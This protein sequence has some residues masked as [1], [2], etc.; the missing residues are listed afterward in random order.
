MSFIRVNRVQKRATQLPPLP[1]PL[2]LPRTTIRPKKLLLVGLACSASVRLEEI[3]HFARKFPGMFCGT[4]GQGDVTNRTRVLLCVLC[5]LPAQR[6]RT[7]TQASRFLKR[8]ALLFSV[9]HCECSSTSPVM[10]RGRRKAHLTLLLLAAWLAPRASAAAAAPTAAPP[11]DGPGG[12]AV[13][14]KKRT[15]GVFI[16]IAVV[17]GTKNRRGSP[18]PPESSQNENT[19]SPSDRCPCL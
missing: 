19:C 18:L 4:R 14:D 10:S 12:G 13:V 2:V 3:Y 7:H 9:L 1:L 11:A 6:A 5:A 17:I 8:A 15:A 16:E